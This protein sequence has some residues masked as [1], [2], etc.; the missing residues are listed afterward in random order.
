MRNVCCW[1]GFVI[2]YPNDQRVSRRVLG[3][4]SRTLENVENESDG[5]PQLI[6]SVDTPTIPALPATSSTNPK[7]L[8]VEEVVRE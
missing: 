2:P 6:G 1:N 4:V 3:V 8:A 5:T 7:L